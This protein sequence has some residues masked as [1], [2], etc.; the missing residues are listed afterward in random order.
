MWQTQVKIEHFSGIKIFEKNQ[1][2]AGFPL[3]KK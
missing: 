3:P 1:P 2:Q